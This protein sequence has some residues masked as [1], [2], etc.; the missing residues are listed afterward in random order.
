MG[1]IIAEKTFVILRESPV[2]TVQK[3]RTFFVSKKLR[4]SAAISQEKIVIL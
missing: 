2:D 4:L 1:K 3:D